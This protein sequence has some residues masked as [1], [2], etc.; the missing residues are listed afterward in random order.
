MNYEQRL[1]AV[2]E[3][4][5]YEQRTM[6][7]ELFYPNQT[8]PVV[9]LSNLSQTSIAKRFQQNNQLSTIDNQSF[10]PPPH[11]DSSIILRRSP[12]EGGSHFLTPFFVV[13]ITCIYKDLHNFTGFLVQYRCR[14]NFS[15]LLCPAFGNV[16]NLLITE[17]GLLETCFNFF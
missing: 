7:Y 9:S 11:S 15:I 3:G 10:P 1:S 8:Q 12:G 5:N 17:I 4:G 6:N 2:G 13:A 16:E 14:Q